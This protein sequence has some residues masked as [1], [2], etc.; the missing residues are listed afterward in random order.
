MFPQVLT[1]PVALC[2]GSVALLLV[3]ERQ[4]IKRAEWL[5]KPL[6]ALACIWAGLASGALESDYGVWILV[7]L[8]LCMAGDVLLIP[9]GQGPAFLGGMLAFLLGHLAYAVGFWQWPLDAGRLLGAIV[10][11]AIVA[12]VVL[13]WLWPYLDKAFRVA[14]VAYVVVISLMVCIAFAISEVNWLI[15]AGALAF[16]VSDLAVARNRFVAPGFGNRLWGLPLYFI[17][18]L[19]I[20]AT[21]T[22]AH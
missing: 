2:L 1:L 5:L 19:M 4:G 18:Q 12:F 3:F 9:P 22:V 6:A 14:V 15:P 21:V 7:G 8:V 16:A 17:S 11:M 10:A 13:R 20:A